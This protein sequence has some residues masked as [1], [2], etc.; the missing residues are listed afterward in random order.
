[1]SH[2]ACLVQ[3]NS[4]AD[5][6]RHALEQRLASLHA[7]HFP[8]ET[9]TFRWRAAEAGFMFSEGRQSTSSVISC[10][11]DH[12]TTLELRERYMRAVCDA[13]TAVTGCTVHEIVVSM[14]DTEPT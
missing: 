4:A 7:N 9:A 14:T 12:P 5:S 1:M 13:W 11:I 6:N 3:R 8:G 2:F 10:Q